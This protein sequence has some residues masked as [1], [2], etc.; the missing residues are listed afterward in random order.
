MTAIYRMEIEG[1]TNERALAEMRSFGFGN[2]HPRVLDFVR[3]YVP[4][5]AAA[6]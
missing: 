3:T 2:D 6:K 5:S 1:W 4:R